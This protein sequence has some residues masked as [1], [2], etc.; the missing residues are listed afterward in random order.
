MTEHPSFHLQRSLDAHYQRAKRQFA[1]RASDPQE[2]AEWQTQ[3]RAA[4]KDLLGIVDENL[5]QIPQATLLSST[6]KGAY[7]EEK[8]ALDVGDSLA[9]LYMLIPKTA[10]PYIPVLAFHGHG[11][12][13]NVILGN[14]PDE[15]HNREQN[16]SDNN[17]AQR[18]AEDG[19]LVCALEQRGFGERVTD[20]VDANTHNSC[21]HLAFEYMLNGQTLLGKRLMDAMIAVNYLKGRD[22]LQFDV[23]ASIGFSG[24]GTTALFLSALDDRIHSTV[25]SSYFCSFK[26]SILG[27]SHCECN[28]VPGIL[29][30]G[31]MG[32]I[33][34]LTAPRNLCIVCG[35]ND[36]IFPISGVDEQ[37]KTVDRA[38]ALLNASDACTRITHDGGHAHPHEVCSQWLK[39]RTTL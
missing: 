16:P 39:T 6:D 7:T 5:P 36:P 11:T 21:R 19:F 8:Y 18:L 34:A 26:Q 4:L 24:G 20:Q 1:F 13:V 28:Y 14:D 27:V 25:V 30:L 17:F 15:I 9:P 35:R 22:D 10:P 2:F 12:G 29:E 37:I 31:E 23:L 32:D 3:F 33:A 38:Y